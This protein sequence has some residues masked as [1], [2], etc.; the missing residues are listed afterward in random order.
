MNKDADNL[1]LTDIRHPYSLSVQY[2]SL[3]CYAHCLRFGL[4]VSARFGLVL[5][6]VIM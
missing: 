4:E 3:S 6:L 2:N 1:D 5:L